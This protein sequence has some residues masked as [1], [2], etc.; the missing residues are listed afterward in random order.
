M[1]Q[2]AAVDA[3]PGPRELHGRARG[4]GS[5]AR[6]GAPPGVRRRG[7]RRGA[8]R[9]RQAAAAAAL[10]PR[11]AA[12]R[13]RAAARGGRRGRARPHGDARA[14]RPRRRR[15]HAPRR[16]GRLVG[17]RPRRGARRRRLP[18]RVRVRRARRDRRLGRGRD[19]SPTPASRSR[20]ARRCSAARRTTPRRTIDAYLERCALKTGKLFEA[21]CLLG[22]GGDPALGAYGLSLGIAFQ[23]ADDILDCAGQTQETGKIPGT[24]LREGTPTMPLLLAAQQDEVV[25]ARAR[26]RPARRR[27][28]ARGRD[29]RARPLPRGRARLRRAR[30]ARSS[31]PTRTARSS[32]PSPTPS[33]IGQARSLDGH[34]RRHQRSI[35][36][37]PRWRRASASTSRTGSRCSS[38][39]TCSRSA[40]SPTSRAACAAATTASTSSRTST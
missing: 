40:S 4:S 12:R 23:I 2:L 29:R 27:P 9:R 17:L 5:R 39:T 18:L 7:R 13:G 38:R 11:L 37:A 25:R 33:W 35:R 22:S 15:A 24:D 6:V 20:A 34:R 31:A 1:T 19:R 8:R 32:R 26:R 28:R 14:R 21:A 30:P 36:S 10:L 3:T 16:A